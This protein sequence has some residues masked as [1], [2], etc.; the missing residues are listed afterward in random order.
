MIY[1]VHGEDLV[2]SRALILNQ[3][4]K[5]GCE[6]RLE[7][8]ISDITP[9]ELLEKSCSNDLFGNPPF[10]VLDVTNAGRTNLD[11]YIKSI[12]KIP[13][14]TTLIVLSG[15]TLSKS[16][17]F[18]KK[19]QDLKARTNL[20]ESAPK[21]NIF[22]FV[23]AVF[24]KQRKKAYTELAK[25]LK[26]DVSTYEILPMMYYGLRTVASAKL[27]SPSY[28]KLH[29]FVKNKSSSQA[30]LFTQEQIIGIFEKF[31]KID[32]KSKLSEIDE[33]LLIPMSIEIVL[34]S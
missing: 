15:K 29:P 34:N 3:Q 25:L 16:N 7:F 28:K 30:K 31:R 14:S 33:E 32:M 19:S 21:S 11:P 22:N 17:L 10:I 9:N 6:S 1:I 5:V 27:D 26:D 18:I 23:D 2:K 8:D 20:N 13:S 24:Y 12:E 4:K